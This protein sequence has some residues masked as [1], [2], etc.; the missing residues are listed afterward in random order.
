MKYLS[1]LV[2]VALT[3]C[4]NLKEQLPAA[5]VTIGAGYMGANASVSVDTRPATNAVVD[6]AT[7]VTKA[8]GLSK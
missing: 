6:G 1:I 3:A 7:T 4:S 5:N 8:F 2:L